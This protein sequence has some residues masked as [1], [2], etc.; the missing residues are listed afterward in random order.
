MKGRPRNPRRDQIAAALLA[1]A[2]LKQV[3]DAGQM[4][5]SNAAKWAHY[6]GFRRCF[7]TDAE[8]RELLAR[9]Q[10]RPEAFA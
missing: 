1:D 4:S 2:P 10:Q 6:L 8:R 3:A 7:V 5:P 9:R